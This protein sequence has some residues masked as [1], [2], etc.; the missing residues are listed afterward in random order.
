MAKNAIILEKVRN[1][2][3][4]AW[5]FAGILGFVAIYI[6]FFGADLRYQTGTVLKLVFNSIGTV[7]LTFGPLLIAFGV[8]KI[9]FTKKLSIGSIFF[10]E[11]L[12][13]IGC[14]LTDTTFD[15][16]GMIIGRKNPSKGYI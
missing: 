16:M 9:V 6:P 13:W 10:G 4:V 5:I 3:K 14:F 15:F 7:C 2:N 11:L 8:I 12:L 1:H